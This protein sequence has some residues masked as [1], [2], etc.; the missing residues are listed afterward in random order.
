MNNDFFEQLLAVHEPAA[1]A[2]SEPAVEASANGPDPGR[3]APAHVDELC[4]SFD[5][6]KATA[7]LA[8]QKLSEAK[9]ELLPLVDAYGHVPEHAPKTTRL[10]G[11]LYTADAT[12]SSTVEV[13]EEPVA[14]LRAE[15][16]RL[17]KPRLF[18]E[19]FD[20]QVKHSLKKDAGGILKIAI[21]GM[22]EDKQAHLLGLFALCFSVGTKA[23]SL[24]VDLSEALKAK[25]AEKAQKAAAKAARAATPKKAKKA[26]K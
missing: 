3:P 15:L 12:T 25:E 16:S 22:A 10:E 4:I 13:K 5:V 21:G 11:I 23:P 17:G 24:S 18:K 20:R 19:I 14:T 6:A 1:G 8:Q 9:G 7:E 2:P 26:G